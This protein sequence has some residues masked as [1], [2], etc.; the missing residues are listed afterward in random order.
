MQN[1]A[2]TPRQLRFAVFLQSFAALLL[3]GAGIVR[4]SALGVDLWAVVFLIL[5]LVAATAA[6]LIL[7]VIRRS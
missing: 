6:V 2:S 1:N 3:L 5:G 4:I 7:R